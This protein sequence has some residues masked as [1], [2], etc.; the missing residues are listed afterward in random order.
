MVWAWQYAGRKS[1]KPIRKVALGMRLQPGAF[2]G[3]NRFGHSLV[4]YVT[5]H[6]VNVVFDLREPD[7]DS[8]ILTDTR[9]WTRGGAFTGIDVQRY[10]RQHPDTRVILRV[11]ECD[12]RKA[13]K[14]H[15]LNRLI[16]FHSQL[17]DDIVFVSDWLRDLYL[18]EF[19]SLK[20][21]S[22][23]I[24]SGASREFHAV[25]PRSWSPP[26][27]LKI[28]THHWS[29]NWYKGWDIYQT[30]DHLAATTLRNQIE[31]TFIGQPWP[32]AHLT[33]TNVLPVLDGASLAAELA[34][35]HVYI[36]GSHNE[37]AGMHY[38]EALACGL[39]ILY[40]T[41]GSLPEYCSAYGLPFTDS[42]DVPVAIHRM[43]QQYATWRNA[44]QTYAYTA[45][46]MAQAYYQLLQQPR[47]AS[48]DLHRGTY[49]TLKI[50]GL[51][52]AVWL[53]ETLSA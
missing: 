7:I 9:P 43:Q 45:D 24:H 20:S 25:T 47:P 15:W 51:Q 5:R 29:S 11:N 13:K 2:G 50:V 40:R 31:F 6:G 38:I 14:T 18:T 17:A 1:M 37:P 22:V 36:S 12:Q 3:G 32:G 46:D 33:A 19:P 42:T 16:F 52:S 21:K 34:R 44:V 10:V 4:S 49:Q 39:P 8:I 41:S 27:P 53:R 48:T 28:V 26:E 30:L 35:H 23:V